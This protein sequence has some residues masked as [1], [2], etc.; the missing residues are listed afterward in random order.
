MLDCEQ[1]SSVQKIYDTDQMAKL[2]KVLQQK[3]AQSPADQLQSFLRDL[4]QKLAILNSDE[5]RQARA[6]LDESLAVAAPAYGKK[7]CPQLP[8]VARFT[9]AQWQQ[10]RD[11]Y[12]N[13]VSAKRQYA[14]NFAKGRDAQ[15]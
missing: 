2:K 8:D 13:Q 14:A 12:Q 3:V 11:E 5:T 9:A 1:W 10:K 6:W 4:K 7:L 15:V